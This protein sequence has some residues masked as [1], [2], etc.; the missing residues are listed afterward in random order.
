VLRC[1]ECNASSLPTDSVCCTE[2]G[3]RGVVPLVHIILSVGRIDFGHARLALP[4]GRLPF[5]TEQ[6]MNGYNRAACERSHM[7]CSI[8]V[9]VTWEWVPII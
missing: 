5:A 2:R 4:D 9:H 8:V 7:P 6:L 3:A 1:T